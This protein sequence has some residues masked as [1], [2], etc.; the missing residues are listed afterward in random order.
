MDY[1]SGVILLCRIY[2]EDDS[3]LPPFPERFQVA[4]Y[5]FFEEVKLRRVFTPAVLQDFNQIKKKSQSS[6]QQQLLVR[7]GAAEPQGG[8]RMDLPGGQI[9]AGW[10]QGVLLLVHREPF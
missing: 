4:K 5:Y 9:S 10:S 6:E 7:A 1:N 3:D 2:K 8:G